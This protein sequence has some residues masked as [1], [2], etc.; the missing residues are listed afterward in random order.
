[1]FTN[2]LSFYKLLRLPFFDESE[3]S[4]R[5]CDIRSP[6]L[7]LL[8]IEHLKRDLNFPKKVMKLVRPSIPGLL[9]FGVFNVFAYSASVFLQISLFVVRLAQKPKS[10]LFRYSFN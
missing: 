6:P 10:V 1:M 7:Q 2:R 4:A 9:F 3:I 8:L 5:R